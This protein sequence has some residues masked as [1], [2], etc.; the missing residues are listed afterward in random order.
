MPTA[1][2]TGSGGLIGSESVRRFVQD[3]YQVVGLENDMRATFF[4]AS[5]STAHTTET[6]IGKY[7]DEFRSLEIDIRDGDGVS[8]VFAEHAKEI[9]LVIHTAAQPSH[10]WAA[11]DPQTDFAVNANG[12]LNLLEATRLYAPSATF[13]FCSTNKVYGDQ[14]NQLPL[15]ELPQRLELP[16]DHRYHR[17]IDT[18]MSIDQSTH[19]LFGVSKTAADL[20]V[21]EY[22][23]YFDMPTVCFR[24]GCLTGPNHA[25]TQLH[26]FL[27]YLMRCT[28][29]GDPY[30]VF[31]YGGKQVRDNIHSADLVA[32]FEAFHRAP[33]A[34][35]VYNIGGG[36]QSNCS[37]LEAIDLCQ[38]IA[39]RELQW[40]LGEENRIGDHRWWISD[41]EPFKGDYPGWDITW[42]VRDILREIHE[43]NGER[44]VTGAGS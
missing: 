25:G 8:R 20:L 43:R 7:R 35:A 9:E 32:A 41:L 11:S 19:S 5:A 31:G 6:L 16:E 30:T 22:G 42:D 18:S 26:G 40:S 28:M 13:I 15:I 10:D 34:A 27:S 12:T 21:Q 29:T 37:M 39:G 38:E 23:R 17:G 14:P 33:R 1:I 3:G 4:G 2:I 36:R 44:W 24:G